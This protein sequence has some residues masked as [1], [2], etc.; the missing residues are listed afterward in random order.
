MQ[1]MVFFFF[2]YNFKYNI[3][4]KYKV[5]K[6]TKLS[7]FKITLKHN[8]ELVEGKFTSHDYFNLGK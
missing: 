1:F 7:S 2:N 3:K 8:L 5:D 4:H 6:I